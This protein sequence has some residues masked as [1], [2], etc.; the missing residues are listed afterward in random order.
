M[1][2]LMLILLNGII[3]TNNVKAQL[4]TVVKGYVYIDG[5]ITKPEE[6][7]LKFLNQSE[8]ATVYDDGRYI[9]IFENETLGTI[10][11]FYI[12]YSN[13]SYEPSETL[14]LIEDQF[15]YNI[16]LHIK[17]LNESYTLEA[18]AKKQE[19]NSLYAIFLFII[20]FLV[21]VAIILII[22]IL[23]S[24]IKQ[25]PK[26]QKIF[27]IR[28]KGEITKEEVIAKTTETSVKAEKIKSIEEQVDELLSKM[29][30]YNKS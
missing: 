2:V 3:I 4:P 16:D 9:I 19:T 15:L 21:I 30:K 26:I 14:T 12:I 8:K 29:E 5:N 10:G 13:N 20:I 7:H 17:T 23:I 24:S 11:T 1:I 28:K 6:I 18:S 27:Y 25:K 22:L